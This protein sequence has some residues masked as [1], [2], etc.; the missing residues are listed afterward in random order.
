MNDKLEK[1]NLQK[2]VAE[3]NLITT[4]GKRQ[5]AKSSLGDVRP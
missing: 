5:G 1:P 4:C 2:A 3:K